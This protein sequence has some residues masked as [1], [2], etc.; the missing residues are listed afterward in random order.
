MDGAG[1]INNEVKARTAPSP[2]TTKRH[3]PRNSKSPTNRSTVIGPS[4]VIMCG[5]V[6]R[7][8]RDGDRR[9]D[10][11]G[12]ARQTKAASSIT[13]ASGA[14]LVRRITQSVG[15][16]KISASRASLP[17]LQQRSAQ[18]DDDPLIMR[19]CGG[20]H[21]FSRCS[22][23]RGEVRGARGHARLS[24]PPPRSARQA[25]FKA[26][27]SHLQS[28]QFTCYFASARPAPPLITCIAG[29]VGRRRTRT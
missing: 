18:Q 24:T 4:P 16:V 27:R 26:P 15:S 28:H 17:R 8:T 11:T 10:V 14:W 12:V 19:V 5:V 2:T 9:S 13:R 21:K 23:R 29:I 1:V 3:G 25:C 22:R 6:A 20:C 7:E